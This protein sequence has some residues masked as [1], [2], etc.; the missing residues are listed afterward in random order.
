MSNLRR[1]LFWVAFYLAIIFMLG[2]LD[3]VDRPVIN[4]A[5]YFYILVFIVVPC[6]V[7]I[8]SFYR[9]PQF[10]SM[11]FWASIYFALSRILDR[12][13]SAADSFETIFVE[14]VLLEVG[15][16]LSYQ[17]A[18]DLAHSASLVDTMAQSTFPNQAIEVEEASSLIRN[19]ITRSRRYHRPLSLLIFQASPKDKEEY[20]ELFRSFQ[21][22]LLSRFS[23]ARMGQLIGENIR[24][25][26]LLLRDRVG[27]FVV[28]CPE[29][30]KENVFMLGERISSK[31]EDGT[32][33]QVSWGSSSFPDEALT[34]DDMLARAR[35]QMKTG[36]HD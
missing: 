31:L 13:L 6:V 5:S 20:R 1:S 25:T 9:A 33:L 11:I 30:D 26:D 23:S 12:S 29:T 7:L 14:V 18:V 34:F 28:V 21:R 36:Q 22:D 3:R 27:R 4:L 24:Q 19:E 8:P 10:I 32:G 16:W 15:V 35:E 17:F 2:Q